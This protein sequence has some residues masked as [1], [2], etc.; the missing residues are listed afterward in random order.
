MEGDEDGDTVTDG[1]DDSSTRKMK[2]HER[3]W[4]GG[5][6]TDS[7]ESICGSDNDKKDGYG[8]ASP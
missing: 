2:L 8:Y 5:G 3:A 4:G 7:E 6:S 1:Y